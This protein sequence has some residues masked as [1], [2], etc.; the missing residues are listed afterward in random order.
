MSLYRILDV[1][2]GSACVAAVVV[3]A[4]VLWLS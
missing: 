1:I 4:V 3:I 2:A